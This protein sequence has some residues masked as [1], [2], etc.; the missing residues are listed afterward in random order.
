MKSIL[1]LA[2]VFALPTFA[3]QA[4]LSE[5]SISPDEREIAFVSGGDIW[6]VPAG[7]GEARLLVADPATESR[8]LWS[9]DG[10]RVAFVST[11]TG[12]GDIYVLDLARGTLKRVTYD[13]GR[14]QLD[15]WSS[16]GKTLYFSSTSRE[17]AGM[18]DVWRVSAEGGT[19]MQ[20][21]AER[22]I[23]EYFSAPTPDGT[24]IA[25]AA[26]GVA[27]G[28]WWRNGSSHIDTSQIWRMDLAS[29]RYDPLTEDGAR[30]I[31]PMW[32]GET[33]YFVSDRGGA[34]NLW[35]R[36]GKL[37]NFTS[38]RVLWPA[39]AGNTIVFERDFGIWRYDLASR[40]A[41]QINVTLRGVPAMQALD[42]R[43]VSER[44]ADLAL[45][46]DGKKLAFTAR[47]DVF[48]ASAKDGG[49][50][51]RITN[52]G[53]LEAQ[54]VWSPDSRSLVYTSDRGGRSHLFR[55]DFATERETQLTEGDGN[56]DTPRFSGD[57]KLLA[58]QRNR[59]ELMVLD[60][61]TR[62]TRSVA[63]ALLDRPPLGSDR[64]FVWSPDNKWIAYLGYSDQLFRNVYVVPASGG[65]ARQASFLANVFTDSLA[66]SRDGRYL[67]MNTTQ[68]TEPG[69]IARIDLVPATPKFREDQFRDLFNEPKKEEKEKP[70][71][72]AMP[73][74]EKPAT[75]PAPVSPQFDGI[76]ERVSL[77]PTGLDAG[78]IEISPDGKW[79]AFTATVGD[80]ENV[81]VYSVD[82]LATEPA[83]PKQLSSTSGRKTAL[84]FSSDSKEV[85]YLDGGRIAAAT[86]DPVKPRSIAVTAEMDV[87]FVRE[88]D[89]AFAQ[90][91]RYMRDNFY[92]PAMHGVDWNATR[93]RFAPRV[94]AART[95]DEFRRLLSLMVG[96]LNASHL[97]AAAPADQVRTT[98]GRIGV[99]FDGT[100]SGLRVSEV[101]PLSPADIAKIKVG[102][103]ITAVDGQPVTA[104][105]N[106]DALLE[107][108]IGK[109]TSI[110]L[111]PARTVTLQP[112]R[113]NEEKALTY[114]AWVNAN[115]DYVHRISNG[116]LGYVHMIDM[117]AESLAQ[118]HLDL[119]AENRSKA[120]VVVDLRN[121][122]GGFVNVYAIDV[123]ARKPYLTMT[124]RDFPPAGARTVLGQRS[125]EKPT[126]LVVNRHSLS[127][128]E[129]FAEGYRAL[130]LGKTV[131]E[132]TAGWIIYT[133]NVPLIDGTIFRLP[134]IRISDAKGENME[135][136][137]RPVDI[138]VH[139]PLGATNDAQL[140]A[141]VKQLL[142]EIQ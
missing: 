72:P 24:A 123:L 12:N 126:I 18:N 46:P 58:F 73:A 109:R 69:Q 140:D 23:N 114:R 84:Q 111:E 99:R 2:L 85:F 104:S 10:K 83:V 4:A 9:P 97:G 71:L 136:N 31:W 19:P 47:G 78:S 65:T 67:L 57:G 66:W 5:P 62:Q 141:A 3:Q 52:T 70:A 101:I 43:R 11:R 127:D 110:T 137:P 113:A 88:R 133:A 135:R 37:T 68:R 45:S 30:T 15:A 89:E 8:P 96:E 139:R 102:D 119:D 54:L 112:V 28:Q 42:R 128:A 61:A 13:D 16:D 50:A 22:Y 6:T 34:E 35:S 132:P 53:A 38:G 103:V 7:G 118:L 20:V 134:F 14:D 1:A 44:F 36:N 77:L 122:N 107:H 93:E 56:D 98:T 51:T 26:R 100:A 29:R 59:R 75:P 131:G 130:G 116:R 117:G 106:F 105:T 92:D 87:D 138:T 82:E 33:L 129:D 32:S 142:S 21:T 94:A 76:R 27:S 79:V 115:R 60:L 17:I 49:D 86:L 124:F 41:A 81:Y 48:A 55:Y 74:A 80:N 91:W 108:R 40:N 64:P 39:L 120:G 125:L 95:G 121:N 90:A 25:F 63:T